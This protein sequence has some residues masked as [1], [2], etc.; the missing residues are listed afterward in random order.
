MI[1]Y[2]IVALFQLGIL[3]A[4]LGLLNEVVNLKESIIMAGN[5]Q[6]NAILAAVQ[7]AKDDIAAALVKEKG[8]IVAQIQDLK[9]QVANGGQLSAADFDEIINGVGSIGSTSVAAIDKVSDEDGAGTETGG[10]GGGTG[11]G[12]SQP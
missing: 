11:G 2:G 4:L 12:E 10:T 9:T 7:K 5:A 8:E 1:I 6:K 3:I